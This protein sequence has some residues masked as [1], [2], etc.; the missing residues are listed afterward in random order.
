MNSL[1]WSTRAR[2]EV[3]EALIAVNSHLMRDVSF[4]SGLDL[5]ALIWLS[6]LPAWASLCGKQATKGLIGEAA[7]RIISLLKP[8]Q[9]LEALLHAEL[10][11]SV[12]EAAEIELLVRKA[13]SANNATLSALST[14]E[15]TQMVEQVANELGA[16]QKSASAA[17]ARLESM[18]IELT[19]ARLSLEELNAKLN[20][21]ANDRSGARANERQQFEIDAARILAR[22]LTNLDSELGEDYQGRDRTLSLATSLGIEAIAKSGKQVDFSFELHDDPEGQAQPGQKVN[23]VC[24][25]YKWIRNGQSVILYKALVAS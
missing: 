13:L 10:L 1:K 23:V 7:T 16:A 8:A 3:S 12:V 6:S 14:I 21:V 9:A 24:A 20:A 19:E 5:P 4:W 2:R 18:Q 15:N 22:V 17:N 11:S 25:G